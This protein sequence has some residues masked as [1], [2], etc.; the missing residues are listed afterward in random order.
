M[1]KP[2]FFVLLQVYECCELG[3]KIKNPLLRENCFCPTLMSLCEF[4]ELGVKTLHLY[5]SLYKSN[6]MNTNVPVKF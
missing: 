6:G 2:A 5:L 4:F 3:V 1:R